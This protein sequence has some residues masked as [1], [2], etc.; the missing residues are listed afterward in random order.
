MISKLY[1][2]QIVYSDTFK[3]KADRQYVYRGDKTFNRGTIYL[4]QKDGTL[5]G[6]ATLKN[7]FILAINPKLLNETP[8]SG[9]FAYQKINELYPIDKEIF[10]EK[11]AKSND[12]YEEI[13]R[14]VPEDIGE[15]IMG[16][17]ISGVILEKE[18]W[19]YYPGESLASHTLGF[20][21]FKGD[22]LTGRYGVE[23]YYNDIL[24]RDEKAAY[25]NFFA[26]IFSN[27]KISIKEGEYQ[28]EGDLVLSI[29]PSVQQ[30]LEDSLLKVKNEYSA[31]SAGG[32]IMNPQNGEIYALGVVPDFN[33][34]I[35]NEEKDAGIFTNPLIENVYEMGSIIKPLTV[36]AGLDQGVI[37]AQTTYN[38]KG[39]LTLDGRTFYNYDGKARGVVPMQEVLSQSLNTGVAFI[40]SRLGNARFAEY[41]RK[42]GF[43]EETG[44]D[45][46][47]ELPGLV[48]N[49]ESTR[50]IEY[51]TASFGQGIALTTIGT[52]R[53]LASLGNGGL[54]VTP[55]V[56]KE[57]RYKVGINKMTS[58]DT[59]KRVLKP[60][61]SEEISRMLVEVVDKALLGGKIK[62]E[63]YTIA[64]K[65]GTAQ[66]SKG[67]GGGYYD[68]R[69]LH[70]FFGY[71]PAYKPQ[72][73]VFFYMYYPKNVRF[74][75]ET[76]TVPFS[77]TA[78][79]LIN[80]YQI[81]P[82]R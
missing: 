19:R 75:S 79:F 23:R 3:Q 34:N 74:A 25:A 56:V 57:V 39:S 27:I 20:V 81:P 46:P 82:D 58:S 45:L 69:F 18:R 33:P 61:T 9:E 78:K 73:I 50:D 55:H 6:A 26:Q 17:K 80:Y 65:T 59:D 4:T 47:G 10:L 28:G 14:R 63:H 62:M 70:S 21:G 71:F 31:D 51:A 72:F 5:V 32:I 37:T 67:A 49:L 30:H 64:A 48:K 52:V 16:L 1:L 36:A 11:A 24:M 15:K 41:L 44:I 68:D 35:Y 2:V 8:E 60:E 66:I 22:Q 43:G 53:A 13:A 42:Y 54:L 12:P 40:V 7:G 76:L 29:E 38:D 77:E